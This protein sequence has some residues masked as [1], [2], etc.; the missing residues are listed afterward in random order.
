MY[1][2]ALAQA[3]ASAEFE[4]KDLVDFASSIAAMNAFNRNKQFVGVVFSEL[5]EWRLLALPS[6]C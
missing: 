6:R 5:S 2:A 4:P 3:V 1:R